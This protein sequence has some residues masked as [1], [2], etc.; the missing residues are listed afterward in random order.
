MAA[1]IG[2]LLEYDGREVSEWHLSINLSTLV[3]LLST[4]VRANMVM[5]VSG[6]ISQLK[7]SWFT[8]RPQPLSHLQSFDGGSRSGFGALRL[9]WMLI[10][11]VRTAGSLAAYAMMAATIVVLSFVV[12]PFMQQAIKTEICPRIVANV[13]SS[14]PVANYVIGNYYRIAAGVWEITV[15]MKGTMIQG[16]TNPR[17]KDLAIKASCP[18]GNCTF[19]DYGTGVTHSS[20]GLCSRCTDKTADVNGPDKN[21]NITLSMSK[22]LP[23]MWISLESGA[24]FLS[25]LASAGTMADVTILAAS[26]SP[27][28]NSTDGLVCPH[29]NAP[30]PASKLY[31]GV[32]DFVAATCTLY[33][34]IKSYNGV[35]WE[36]T[37]N[38]TIVAT[39]EVPANLSTFLNTANYTALRSPCILDNTGTWYTEANVSSAPKIAGHTWDSVI[40][41]GKNITAPDACLYKL[42]PIYA[43][44]MSAFITEA[45]DGTCSYDT[46]QGADLNCDERWWLSP[47]YN[48]RNASYQ[49]LSAAMDDFATAVTAKFRTSGFGPYEPLT[50]DQTQGAG[51]GAQGT[52]LQTSI[53]TSL[54]WRWLF[55]PCDLLVISAALLAWI[56]ARGL[57]QSWDPIWKASVLPL[58]LN[59]VGTGTAPHDMTI[60]KTTL[61]GLESTATKT[62]VML[63]VGGDVEPR[64]VSDTAVQQG[65][66]GRA[67]SMDSLMLERNS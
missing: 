8:R 28:T 34:C 21:G 29:I 41:S 13:N 24:P 58:V 32:G 45:F 5:I 55:L 67:Y 57:K 27:C 48:Q 39:E 20:L 16:L 65:T 46:R 35:V 64:F 6:V 59:G 26:N 14:I 12:G 2:L 1:I 47:L 62:N 43:R 7:W 60:R 31:G 25:V 50:F 22:Y 38:E 54:D 33:P 23:D 37:L 9:I 18:T 51:Y 61:T 36:G 15:D 4:V 40:S 42:N 53:C 49:S 63:V 19:P 56:I 11:R 66:R 44:A 3:A 17:S 10:G 30:T 52:V